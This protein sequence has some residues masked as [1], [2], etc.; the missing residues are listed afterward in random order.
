M[1]C[2]QEVSDNQAAFLERTHRIDVFRMQ[3]SNLDA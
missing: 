1:S 3:R 2:P